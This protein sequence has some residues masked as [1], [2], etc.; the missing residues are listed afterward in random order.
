M[1]LFHWLI[2]RKITTIWMVVLLLVNCWM[3]DTISTISE[4]M[5]GVTTCNDGTIMRRR[6][7]EEYFHATLCTHWLHL[8]AL[9][10][11]QCNQY[12]SLG[13]LDNSIVQQEL[14]TVAFVAK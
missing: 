14:I 6:A 10:D 5:L 11:R 4:S 13:L 3:A 8:W 7:A 1:V 12:K 9:L 2:Q